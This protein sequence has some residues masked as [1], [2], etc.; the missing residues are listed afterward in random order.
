MVALDLGLSPSRC[1][2]SLFQALCLSQLL[3]L[4]STHAT[5]AR[6][7]VSL[8]CAS[9]ADTP[10]LCLTSLADDSKASFE[11]FESLDAPFLAA[12]DA[13]CAVA[14]APAPLKNG[15]FGCYRSAG[16]VLL[17]VRVLLFFFR[18]ERPFF[19]CHVLPVSACVCL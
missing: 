14:P 6:L 1:D 13:M 3:P 18:G 17:F 15:W 11:S 4:A 9:I 2:V 16:G 7:G 8:T 10:H 12:C 19:L 5:L